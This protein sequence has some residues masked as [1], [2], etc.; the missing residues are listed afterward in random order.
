[1]E[2]RADTKSKTCIAR[3]TN[4]GNKATGISRD[5]TQIE[6]ESIH[7]KKKKDIDKTYKRERG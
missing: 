5:R 3:N 4:L 2:V 7:I 1:M 6:E